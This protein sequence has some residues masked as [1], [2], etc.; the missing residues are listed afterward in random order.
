MRVYYRKPDWVHLG[1]SYFSVD[2]D[3]FLEV[4][5]YDELPICA[6]YRQ[7]NSGD[8]ISTA[9]VRKYGVNFNKVGLGNRGFNIDSYFVYKGILIVKVFNRNLFLIPVGYLFFDACSLVLLSYT[10][11]QKNEAVVTDKLYRVLNE[12]SD[13]HL[14]LYVFYQEPYWIKESSVDVCLYNINAQ[15]DM[16][17]GADEVMVAR[18][19][20]TTVPS[21]VY[22]NID[23]RFDYKDDGIYYDDN[24]IYSEYNRHVRVSDC[25]PYMNMWIIRIMVDNNIYMALFLE[26]KTLNYI[27]G[28]CKSEKFVADASSARLTMLLSDMFDFELFGE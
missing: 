7:F 1:C 20:V 13:L 15:Q 18:K 19:F 2:S 14:D 27:G 17:C 8:A 11:Y 22:L 23:D 28:I 26:Q 10:I 6:S 5:Y 25:Y 4:G 3:D 24:K 12:I 21:S 9:L 16:L